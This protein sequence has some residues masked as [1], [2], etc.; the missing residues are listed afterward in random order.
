MST[1]VGKTHFLSC[2]LHCQNYI[3]CWTRY[4]LVCLYVHQVCKSNCYKFLFIQSYV[5][6]N[7]ILK[8]KKKSV[9]FELDFSI[10]WKT[11]SIQIQQAAQAWLNSSR[12]LYHL[13]HFKAA[14][15]SWIYDSWNLDFLLLSSL[16]YSQEE[17]LRFQHDHIW[18]L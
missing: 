14:Y 5:W 8:K 18:G 9:S 2:K 11:V 4:N 13:Y 7:T 3:F 17:N 12:Q 16:K 15:E 1:K 6:R 10:N